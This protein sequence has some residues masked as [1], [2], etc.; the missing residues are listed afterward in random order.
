MS[1][2]APSVCGVSFRYSDNGAGLDDVNAKVHA[3]EPIAPV[4]E[5]GDGKMTFTRILLG[6]LAPSAGEVLLDG[7]IIR[8]FPESSICMLRRSVQTVFQDPLSSLGPRMK[9]SASIAEPLHTLG[10]LCS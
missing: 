10:V 8:V 6:L 9:I 2:P 4:G 5:S 7:E 1:E 3:G